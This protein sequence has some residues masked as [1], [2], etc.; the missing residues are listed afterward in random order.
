[1]DDYYMM[2]PDCD[3]NGCI[4]CDG[5]GVVP[6]WLADP[7][8]NECAGDWVFRG[9]GKGHPANRALGR[10]STDATAARPE[11]AGGG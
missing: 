6:T 2:C 9:G 11:G 4:T 8:W 5:D 3:G 1:M 7:A 10:L